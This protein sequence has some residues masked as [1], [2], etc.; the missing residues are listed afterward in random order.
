MIENLVA[1]LYDANHFVVAFR[2]VIESS[3]AH[4]YLSAL[5]KTSKVAEVFLRNYPSLIRITAVGIQ[6]QQ[7][8]V[9]ELLGHTNSVTSVSFSQDGQVLLTTLLASPQMAAKLCRALV[10]RRSEY[11][12]QR[13][14][15]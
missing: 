13:Q 5:H 2:E 6:R 15:T 14:A 1:F 7:R 8:P 9:L 12:M 11:G 4:I 10:T 3:V